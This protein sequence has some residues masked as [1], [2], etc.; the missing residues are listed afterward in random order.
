MREDSKRINFN[1][2]HRF[3]F[4]SLAHCRVTVT[5]IFCIHLHHW[6]K[7]TINEKDAVFSQIA[8]GN[9]SYTNLSLMKLR[10]QIW[11]V[12][13]PTKAE[14]TSHSHINT[15]SPTKYKQKHCC[16]CNS[17]QT[18]WREDRCSFCSWKEAFVT[19]YK[20][21]KSFSVLHNPHSIT[22]WTFLSK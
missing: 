12:N 20:D 13:C 19:H 10:L 17:S 3:H 2:N 6:A 22:H 16:G 4:C 5:I 7:A 14:G 15:R 21:K 18:N 1:C 8:A 9:W 11:D